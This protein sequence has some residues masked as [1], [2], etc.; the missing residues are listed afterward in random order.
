MLYPCQNN[1]QC[2]N[3]RQKRKPLD[4][5]FTFLFHTSSARGLLADDNIRPVLRHHAHQHTV[6]QTRR[7]LAAVAQITRMNTDF[8]GAGGLNK[9]YCAV[10]HL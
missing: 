10:V 4:I 6:W 7:R 5:R 3:Q 1:G 8:I 2:K 9:P